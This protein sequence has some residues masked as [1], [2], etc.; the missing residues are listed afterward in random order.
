[1]YKSDTI[2]ISQM[3]PTEINKTGVIVKVKILMGKSDVLRYLKTLRV[4]SNESP[5]SLL[6]LC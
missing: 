1:M 2:L 4:I 3:K 6:N 5:V